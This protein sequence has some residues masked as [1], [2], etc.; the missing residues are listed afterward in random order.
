MR[1][2]SELNV[3]SVLNFAS[4]GEEKNTVKQADSLTKLIKFR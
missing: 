3:Y 4:C 1:N 2:I